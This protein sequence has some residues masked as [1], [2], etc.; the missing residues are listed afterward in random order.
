M[1]KPISFLNARQLVLENTDRLPEEIVSLPESFDRRL[2]QVITTSEDLPRFNNSGVDGYAIRLV[3]LSEGAVLKVAGVIR[4]G[5]PWLEAWPQNTCLRILT[6]APVPDE[7]EAI[8][9]QE[10][11][12]L[13]GEEQVCINRLPMKNEHIR[14]RGSDTKAGSII[15]TVGTRIS[16][17]LLGTLAS[18]G[19]TEVVVSEKPNIALLTTGDEVLDVGVPLTPG[20]VWNTSRYLLQGE[21]KE[22]GGRVVWIGHARDDEAETRTKIA[23]ALEQAHLLLVCGGVSVGSYDLV[24]VALTSL[25]WKPIVQGVKQRPG[26]PF[27]FG[28]LGNKGIFG[29]PGNPVS[30]AVCFDQYVRPAINAMQG[31]AESWRQTEPAELMTDIKKVKGLHHFVRATLHK[32]SSGREFVAPTGAQGSHIFSSM[33]DAECLIHLPEGVDEVLAGTIVMVERLTT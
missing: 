21:V 2:A 24:T 16:P 4:A 30:T 10:W 26:K 5:A 17:A 8:V 33:R 13:V 15:A 28:R 25:G 7:A 14:W 27:T 20:K 6:G 18:M 19:K 23:E 22:A 12:N 31:Q 1:R 9:M 3:G 32:D 11:T 29:L